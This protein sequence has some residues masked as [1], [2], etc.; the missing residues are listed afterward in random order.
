[1][2]CLSVRIAQPRALRVAFCFWGGSSKPNETHFGDLRAVKKRNAEEDTDFN[3]K[4]RR[5]HEGQS[6]Q[7]A[8]LY[9]SA[10]GLAI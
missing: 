5:R 2:K 3:M 6:A 4:K 7:F 8:R 10:Q 1:M 9:A